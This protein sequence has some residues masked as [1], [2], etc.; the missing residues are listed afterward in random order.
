MYAWALNTVFVL[1]AEE[2]GRSE[3]RAVNVVDEK[4]T[5]AWCT[6]LKGLE[7]AEERWGRSG[8]CRVVA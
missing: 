1:P 7:R 8:V 5:W 3:R 4:V 6:G 2:G